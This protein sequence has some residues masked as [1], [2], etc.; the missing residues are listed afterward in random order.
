MLK[1]KILSLGIL[2]LAGCG[3]ATDRD[4]TYSVKGKVIYNGSPVAQANVMFVPENGR[5]ASGT[6]DD[7]GEFTLTTYTSGDGAQPGEHQVLVTKLEPASPNDPY[8]TRKSLVPEK[9]GELKTSPLK[10]SINTGD[11]SEITIELKD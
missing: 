10:Q 6:S 2:L 7:Q 9:Y 8:A 3:G 1:L 11:N 5:P 4:A